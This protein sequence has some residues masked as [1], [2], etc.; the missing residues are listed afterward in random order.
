MSYSDGGYLTT[1]RKSEDTVPS[2][3]FQLFDDFQDER[4]DTTRVGAYRTT[5]EVY[6]PVWS[7][8]STVGPSSGDENDV[9][10]QNGYLIFDNE[11]NGAPSFE[12]TLVDSPTL[13]NM[14]WEFRFQYAESFSP[15]SGGTDWMILQDTSTGE[16]WQIHNDADSNDRLQLRYNDG[17]SWTEYPTGNGSIS[18]DNWHTIRVTRQNGDEW[19]FILDGATVNTFTDSSMP[20]EPTIGFITNDDG[21]PK[22]RVD[23]V[24]SEG[25]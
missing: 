16:K 25:V 12:Y 15:S 7:F 22:L 9:Y 5:S 11:N 3:E 23:Y 24:L 21:S 6:R 10:S 2:P 1:A 4:H 18:D 20:T 14:A 13:D 19:E 17:S 8:N